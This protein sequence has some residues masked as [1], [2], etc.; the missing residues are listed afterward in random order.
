MRLSNLQIDKTLRCIH[1]GTRRKPIVG[2]VLHDTAGAG[3]HNDTLYLANPSDGRTVSVD[4]TVERNGSIWQLNPNLR[5]FAT[6]HAGRATRFR[7]LSNRNVT[8][9]TIGI[10]IVQ[11]ADLSLQPRYPLAQTRAVAHLCAAL[12]GE[13]RLAAS[14]ITTHRAVVTD[15]SRTDPR[16]FDFDAFWLA[17]R[18]VLGQGDLAEA[19]SSMAK[20][21][22]PT[23]PAERVYSVKGNDTLTKIAK[24]HGV[25]IKEI[26]KRNRL[27]SSL[28]VVGQSL[29]IPT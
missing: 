25:T 15:G 13:F 5:S 20:I 27:D 21:S 22:A 16:K 4:F 24:K 8:L 9:S 19:A 14:D 10:E 1:L 17:F 28:V 3:T 18:D 2:V 11:K 26:K 7:N 6:Y 12:C 23:G 29:V